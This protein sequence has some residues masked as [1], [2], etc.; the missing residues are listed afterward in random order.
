M[1]AVKPTPAAKASPTRRTCFLLSHKFYRRR[2]R[3]SGLLSSAASE[4]LRSEALRPDLHLMLN[5]LPS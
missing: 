3:F 5:S 2:Q 1:E 4:S